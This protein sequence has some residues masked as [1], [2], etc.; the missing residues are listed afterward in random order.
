MLLSLNATALYAG[1]AIGS[2]AGGVVLATTHGV[3][4]LCLVSAVFGLASALTLSTS[5][6]ATSISLSWHPSSD[7]AQGQGH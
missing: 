5:T 1:V 2:A 7:P 4:A 3:V 6:P